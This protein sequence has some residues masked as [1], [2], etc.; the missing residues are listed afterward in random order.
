MPIFFFRDP[1]KNGSLYC[2]SV[3][4]RFVWIRKYRPFTGPTY[5]SRASHLCL[6]LKTTGGGACGAKWVSCQSADYVTLYRDSTVDFSTVGCRRA[7][8]T[9]N[10]FGLSALHRGRAKGFCI[11]ILLYMRS[12]SIVYYVLFEK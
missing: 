5:L 10:T 2:R 12:T 9:R 1:K 4:T 8:R 6:S 7:V 3:V 11:L